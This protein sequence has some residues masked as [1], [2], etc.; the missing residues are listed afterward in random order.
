MTVTVNRDSLKSLVREL[1]QEVLWEME[2]QVPDPDLGLE[3]RSEIAT[4]LR[5]PSEQK[6]PL[7]SLEE[8]RKELGLLILA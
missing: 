7:R 3:L 6:E 5:K 1:M 2:Q 8:V 4:Y